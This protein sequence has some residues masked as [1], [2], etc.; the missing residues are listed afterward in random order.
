MKHPNHFPREGQHSAVTK[1]AVEKL[2]SERPQLNHEVHYTIG[3]SVE[4]RVYSNLAAER[5]AAITNGARRL[6]DA[7]QQL[8]NGIE[9]A[10]P[11]ARTEYIRKQREAAS[12]QQ[13]RKQTITR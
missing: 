8:R 6:N 10:Q 4:A 12:M 2:Q 13:E 7:S 11:D 5:E 1:E 9:T 3:G